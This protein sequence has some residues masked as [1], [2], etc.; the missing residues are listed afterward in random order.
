[1]EPPH[2]SLDTEPDIE[3]LQI[4]GWR[5][6]SASD[7]AAVVSGLTRAV[8]ELAMAGVRHRHPAASPREQFLRLAIVTLG[9]VLARK[10]YPE[11]DT[12]T[13]M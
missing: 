11:I 3:R 7:K 13:L 5:R 6:M 10:A 12:L 8:Y 9:P 1:V 4:E 2:L